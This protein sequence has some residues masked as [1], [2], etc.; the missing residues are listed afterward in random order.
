M[1]WSAELN[2]LDEYSSLL[3]RAI[4]IKCYV[5]YIG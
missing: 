3:Q 5:E 1:F 4:L 2:Y